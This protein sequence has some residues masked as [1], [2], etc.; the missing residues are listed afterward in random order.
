MKY[1]RRLVKICSV[2]PFVIMLMT[3]LL[4]PIALFVDVDFFAWVGGVLMYFGWLPA[5]IF[6][7]LGIVLSLLSPKENDG[8]D[9]CVISLL[10]FSLSSCWGEFIIKTFWV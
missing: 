4:V 5:F 3:V 6:S 2:L 8:E 10:A 1:N 9:F 7:V